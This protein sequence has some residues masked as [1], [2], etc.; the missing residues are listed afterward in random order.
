MPRKLP[1]KEMQEIAM[2]TECWHDSALILV[3]I[4]RKN[5]GFY[6]MA[7][8]GYNY[9]THLRSCVPNLLLFAIG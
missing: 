8:K 1:S 7:Q 5:P 4:N 3:A 6:I 9:I 2:H